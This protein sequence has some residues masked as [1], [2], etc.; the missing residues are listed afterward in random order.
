[1]HLSFADIFLHRPL[2]L[3]PVKVIQRHPV[4][5]SNTVNQEHPVTSEDTVCTLSLHRCKHL[6]YCTIFTLIKGGGQKKK[7]CIIVTTYVGGRT[8]NYSKF[9]YFFS[10]SQFIQICKEIL[11]LVGVGGQGDGWQVPNQCQ[12]PSFYF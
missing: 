2:H 4:L 10:W 5:P 8:G 9:I 1:M 6:T 3:V 11:L 12:L 7:S